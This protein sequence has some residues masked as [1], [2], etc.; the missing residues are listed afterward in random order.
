M[1]VKQQKID[2]LHLS[3]KED[4]E[5]LNKESKYKI[6]TRKIESITTLLHSQHS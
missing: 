5:I 6:I 4:K 2:L 3:T 1:N